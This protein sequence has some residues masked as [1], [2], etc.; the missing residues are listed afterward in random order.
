LELHAWLYA[1]HQLAQRGDEAA[2]ESLIATYRERP[3]YMDRLSALAPAAER[4]W[5]DLLAPQGV[6]TAAL[7]RQVAEREVDRLKDDLAA[8]G[9]DPL[10][11]L[12]IERI[13]TAWVAVQYAEKLLA[14]GLATNGIAWAQIEHRG[15]HAERMGRA[16][17]RASEAL[18]R[19]RRLR[20][21]AVQINLADKQINV[22]R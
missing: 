8:G 13:A 7:T 15:R 5:L 14:D 21:G 1:M 19:V 20:L 3:E 16:F 10:E 6:G 11:R 4:A 2:S 22:A 12:L 18:A 17:L 9:T